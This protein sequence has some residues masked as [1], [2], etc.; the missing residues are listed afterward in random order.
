MTARSLSAEIGLHSTT[1]SKIENGRRFPTEANVA[2]WCAACGCPGEAPAII[3]RLQT[4]ESAYEEWARVVRRSGLRV[5]SGL[6][7]QVSFENTRLFRIDEPIVVPG[8]FQVPAYTRQ[9]HRFMFHLLGR[10]EE[11]LEDGLTFW[12]QRT[13]AT[14][15]ARRRI[16]AVLGEQVLYTRITSESDHVF[17][18]THLLNLA[19]R[20]YISLG[21]IPAAAA[22]W[23][24]SNIGFWIYDSSTVAM[25]TP[26]A[27][28]QVRSAAEVA[29][30]VKM[31]NDLQ[32]VAVHGREARRLIT[33]AL[34]E[35]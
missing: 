18:L 8:L 33:E 16:V 23:G 31:F 29:L 7:S 26:T 5:R 25:E 35:L 19:E 24:V 20:Q 6:H 11:S 27:C 3:E 22:R 9:M 17:Q 34:A 32:R 10:S 1:M 21:I 2:A 15:D 30:Y 4:I 28:I 14:L 13:E 12:A